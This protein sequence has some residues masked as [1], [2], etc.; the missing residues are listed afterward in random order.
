M[1]NLMVCVGY[2]TLL[3]VAVYSIFLQ[4]GLEVTALHN[5][6]KVYGG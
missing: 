3:G 5:Y 1:K 6:L 2:I 4:V